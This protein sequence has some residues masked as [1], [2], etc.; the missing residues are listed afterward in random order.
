MSLSNYIFFISCIKF[1]LEINL[2]LINS[3]NILPPYKKRLLGVCIKLLFMFIS[4]P[5][6][7]DS[8][9]TNGLLGTPSVSQCK[10]SSVAHIHI[11]ANELDIIIYINLLASIWIWTMPESFTLWNGGSRW[12]KTNRGCNDKM[13]FMIFIGLCLGLALLAYMIYKSV[14]LMS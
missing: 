10:T 8:F 7:V 6:K 2:P 3:K 11:D 5:S 14:D 4:Y 9:Y 12:E 1:Y 13:A